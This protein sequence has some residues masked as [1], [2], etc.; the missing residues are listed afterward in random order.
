[1]TGIDIK[2]FKKLY[3]SSQNPEHKNL[4]LKMYEYEMKY[5]ESITGTITE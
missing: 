1:M 4:K 2:N 5:I 3:Q